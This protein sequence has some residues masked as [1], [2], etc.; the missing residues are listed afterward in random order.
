MYT[1]K[2]L[3][4]DLVRRAAKMDWYYAYSDDMRVW[5]AGKDEYDKFQKDLF[6]LGARNKELAKK[7]RGIVPI[8]I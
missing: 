5:K 1:D 3:Y 6:A 2:D 4:D 8:S 7:I